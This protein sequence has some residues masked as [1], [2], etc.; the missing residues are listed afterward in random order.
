MGGAGRS[1][2][3]RRGE[4][5]EPSPHQAAT[6]LLRGRRGRSHA[7][8]RWRR[9]RR[10]R[11]HPSTRCRN[12]QCRPRLRTVRS[13]GRGSSRSVRRHRMSLSEVCRAS[14]RRGRATL[15]RALLHLLPRLARLSQGAA[16]VGPARAARLQQNKPRRHPATRTSALTADEGE[17]RAKDLE[18]L[19]TYEMAEDLPDGVDLVAVHRDTALRV[20]MAVSRMKPMRPEEIAHAPLQDRHLVEAG[21]R[22]R[23]PKAASPVRQ[24]RL[25]RGVGENGAPPLP[26][27]GSPTGL[28]RRRA[29]RAAASR[30]TTAQGR[31]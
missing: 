21:V 19:S 8:P 20:A 17:P 18:A 25:A 4:I 1:T 26:R 12:G 16:H 15:L 7:S 14:P 10:I 27:G 6:A 3:K 29:A 11:C 23:N 9:R 31:A 5:A 22:R 30:R 2:H 28:R 13:L 24:V